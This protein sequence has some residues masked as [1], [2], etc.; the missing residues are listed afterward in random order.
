MTPLLLAALA[1]APVGEE[2]ESHLLRYRFEPGTSLRYEIATAVT[3]DATLPGGG[4]VVRNAGTTIQRQEVLPLPD[5]SPPE[6]VGR[7][8]VHSER[9]ALTAQFDAEPP[10]RFDS[11][12]PGPPPAGYESVAA[13]AKAPLGELTVSETGGVTEAKSL[14]PGADKVDADTMTAG[15]RDLFPHLPV[16]PVTVGETWDEMLTVGVQEGEK[17]RRPWKVRRRCTLVGVE[18][19]VAEIAVTMTPLPP[20][21]EPAYQEQLA[22]K[23]PSGTLSFDVSA[24]RIVALRADVDAQIIGIRGPASLLKLTSSHRQRLIA[25]GPTDTLLVAPRTAAAAAPAVD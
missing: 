18:G 19:G 20:P 4:Q 9:V 21:V 24:G 25:H 16:E 12:D 13:V 2:G 7:L 14:L 6:T 15:Y 22:M 10:T 8:R 3:I 23:C 17:L 11:A 1:L 5:G